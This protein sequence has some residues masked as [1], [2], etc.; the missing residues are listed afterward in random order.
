MAWI[1][2][3]KDHPEI[4]QRGALLLRQ[5]QD[6][7]D[8]GLPM[9]ADV[10]AARVAFEHYVR[11]WLTEC[12]GASFAPD[13]VCP[14]LTP[15]WKAFVEQNQA[16]EKT[17]LR[18][19]TD[20]A[21]KRGFAAAESL[22]APPP[23]GER[24]ESA[25]LASDSVALNSRTLLDQFRRKDEPAEIDAPAGG[26][27]LP[28]SAIAKAKATSP[29]EEP[30]AAGA[31]QPTNEAAAQAAFAQETEPVSLAVAKICADE[32][33][34]PAPDDGKAT[35]SS[36]T[37]LLA[38]ID[39]AELD[40]FLPEPTDK[41]S[42]ALE[43]LLRREKKRFGD[44]RASERF[45]LTIHFVIAMI[46][47]KPVS[48]ITKRELGKVDMLLPDIPKRTRIPAKHKNSLLARYLY[49]KEH[50]WA[51]LERLSETTICKS[52]HSTL[53]SFFD[54]LHQ[55][56]AL[57][58]APY[59]F[60]YVQKNNPAAEDRDVFSPEEA[61]K[62]ASL[63]LFTGCE[64]VARIW[65]PG[66]FFV[67]SF[68]YWG[69]I[70]AL[71]TGMRPAEIAQVRCGDLI[72]IE[73]EEG[74][75]WFFDFTDRLKDA[76]TSSSR[77]MVPLLPLVIELGLL[78]R[79]DILMAAG[80]DRLFPEW[81]PLVKTTGEVKHGHALSKSWQYIKVKFGFTRNGVTLYSARHW[82]AQRL[83]E[84][85]QIAERARHMAMGHATT[86]KGKARLT[87][88]SRTLALGIARMINAISVSDPTVS[89]VSEILL[90]AK[91]RADRGELQRTGVLEMVEKELDAGE[92]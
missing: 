4:I 22:A 31:Q 68:L 50:G 75:V 91:K 78:E 84:I 44:D 38:E 32:T 51:G 90:D 8:R 59:K 9:D 40:E 30:S 67:Q 55:K 3:I 56:A 43:K 58:E 37:G 11:T 5:I 82:F 26:R 88:G 15:A 62:L 23:Q 86:G 10:L 65:N 1:V 42:L 29:F 18:K 52:Y 2:D 46:G 12:R 35:G 61:I 60:V 70:I 80:Y 49:A 69:Y 20:D 17:H 73:D 41:L 48:E 89:K 16:A 27:Q 19:A 28:L 92:D 13:E 81:K 24:P 39:L 53:N 76:K 83:D 54:W 34:V 36:S 87:Y 33:S 6:H 66:G 47:D 74:E 72:S 64:S 71:V 45:G 63:P 25:A 21:Y 79:L 85:G 57:P 14:G 7:L 77:R